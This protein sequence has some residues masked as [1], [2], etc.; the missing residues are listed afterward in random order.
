MRK[1]A[2]FSLLPT[3]VE[4]L[5]AEEF[6]PDEIEI[7]ENYALPFGSSWSK[8]VGAR[9]AKVFTVGRNRICVAYTIVSHTGRKHANTSLHC[10]ASIHETHSFDKVISSSADWLSVVVKPIVNRISD[11]YLREL[12]QES[13][14]IRPALLVR[15]K[16]RHWLGIQFHVKLMPAF[17]Y[18]SPHKWV[19]QEEYAR[20]LYLAR[21]WQYR[22]LG[23]APPSFTTLTL[24]KGEFTDIAILGVPVS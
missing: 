1:Y 5:Q 20:R 9:V 17:Y 6:T 23:I 19:V 16:F 22:L 18:E 3:R 4:I 12:F 11:Q 13:L 7:I 2:L 21:R 24:S 10:L 15:L 8:L 14:S